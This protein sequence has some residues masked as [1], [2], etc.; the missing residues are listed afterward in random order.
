MTF[1][2]YTN[3]GKAVIQSAAL[4]LSG[5]EREKTLELHTL[6]NAIVLL[7]P[8]MKPVEKAA[9]MMTLM[10]LVNSLGADMMTGWKGQE[11]DEDV[12]DGC[13]GCAEDTLPIPAEAFADAGIV[14]DNLRVFSVD[15]A[16]LVVPQDDA[17]SWEKLLSQLAPNKQNLSK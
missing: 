10:R 4:I 1:I 12:C 16:V 5:L 8:E 11:E 6:E 2:N 17:E 9:A 7:K 3:D 13:H 14:F 15:G